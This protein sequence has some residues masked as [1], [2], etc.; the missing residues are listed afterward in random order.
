MIPKIAR[1]EIAI[2]GTNSTGTKGIFFIDKP[3][4]LLD[5]Q[6]WVTGTEATA[7][8]LTLEKNDFLDAGS[9]VAL[10]TISTGTGNQAGKIKVVDLEGVEV[11][12]GQAVIISVSTESSATKNGRVIIRY[13]ESED[14]VAN[15][16]T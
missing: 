7:L 2:S 10:G 16:A 14:L 8:V 9:P 15:L 3:A 5:A 12:A 1:Q 13:I 6:F 11:D 4:R